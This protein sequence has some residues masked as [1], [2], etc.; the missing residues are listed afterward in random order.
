MGYRVAVRELCEFTAKGGDLDI[1]FTPAPSALEGMAGHRLVAQRRGP[2]YQSELPLAGEHGS[3][4]LRGRADGYDP[5]ANRLEEVKTFRGELAHMPESKHRLHWAQLMVYGWLLCQSQGLPEVHLRLVYFDVVKQRETHLDRQCAAS[6]LEAF[7][8][9]QCQA[10]LAWAEQETAHRGQRDRALRALALPF[11]D[12][13][14]GQRQLAEE[15]YR[16]ARAGACLMMEAP[17]GIG[18]TLGTL[19]PQLKALAHGGLDRLFFLAAKTPGRRLAL[20]ALRQL[21]AQRLSLRVLELSARE[22]ACLYPQAACNGQSCPLA[23]GFYDRLG[24]ARQTAA[25]RRWLDRDSLREIAVQHGICP[26][27]LAQEMARWADLVVADYTYYF[28]LGALLY[29]LAEVNG[30]RT[31][32]LVDE[33]H[34]LPSRARGMYS[35]EL[36]RGQLEQARREAP[37]PAVK[38]ALQALLRCWRSLEAVQA[39]SYASYPR[40]PKDLLVAIGQ[41]QAVLSEYA[42]E[43]AVPLPS[44]LQRWY[45]DSLRFSRVAELFG[46]EYIFDMHKPTPDRGRSESN[47][48]LRNMLPAPFLAERFQD[49]YAS[50]LFSA[51]LS[52][53]HFYAD[54]LGLPSGWLW[55]QVDSPFSAGQLQV[56]IARGV[57]TRYARRGESIEPIAALIERQYDER[58][59]NYLAFFSSFDYL[60]R[61]ADRVQERNP[62]LPVWRQMRGMGE[63][64]R[65]AFLANFC[66]AGRG[67]GFA[68]LGGA[69]GEGIDL[70]GDR[71]IGAFVA[72]LG[73][74]QVN[75][76]N[77]SMRRF[78]E[79]RFGAGH[80]YAYLFPGL[81]KVVQAAGRVIRSGD[82]RGTLLLIDDRFALRRVRDLLPGWWPQPQPVRPVPAQGLTML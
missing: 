4:A 74:P 51:T 67:V 11:A 10:F 82:D 48:C 39:G 8:A 70:P 23:K 41:F 14:P 28:D 75:P 25:E 33:A 78:M 73:L 40:P 6:E 69:F 22:K 15:V 49:A 42:L 46:A 9:R 3:L 2:G 13:R 55:R 21:G 44:V 77:E 20:D 1:G 47:I 64:E 79:R 34:N 24:S 18:K 37:T 7:C 65:D 45:L 54:L 63:A 29:G 12:F 53:A 52:P 68:V 61:V 26:Y 57:S 30:W 32:L 38:K 62:L 16:G 80:D 5:A 50:V 56:R 76:V 17:T 58:P 19:F 72:T 43:Q 27:F 71:L 36:S 81:Q 66:S 60:N 59:G 31:L 35:A